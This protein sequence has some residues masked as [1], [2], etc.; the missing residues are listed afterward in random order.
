MS[1]K[2]ERSAPIPRQ[3]GKRSTVS[4][5]RR[6]ATVVQL[7]GMALSRWRSMSGKPTRDHS[8]STPPRRRCRSGSPHMTEAAV[9]RQGSRSGSV[10]RYVTK[11]SKLDRTGQVA[12]SHS[13]GY[14]KLSSPSSKRSWPSSPVSCRKPTDA[15]ITAT[16]AARPAARRLALT[17]PEYERGRRHVCFMTLK[18]RVFSRRGRGGGHQRSR[19]CLG[20]RSGMS[21]DGPGRVT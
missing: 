20:Q 12:R 15:A 1:A 7:P 21:L 9:L 5:A 11:S 4:F 18:A 8:T 13:N 10:L 19:A 16:T 2:S 6:P 17:L 3:T 14:S